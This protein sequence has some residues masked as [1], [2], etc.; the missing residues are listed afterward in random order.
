M[1]VE[2]PRLY[3]R[4]RLDSIF[5]K[6]NHIEQ[7]WSGTAPKIS[8]FTLI[9][10]VLIAIGALI[11]GIF[12]SPRLGFAV[13]N[14]NDTIRDLNL[15]LYA[16]KLLCNKYLESARRKA[17]SDGLLP[18]RCV[19]DSV[20]NDTP[21]KAMENIAIA[22]QVAPK[23]KITKSNFTDSTPPK[24]MK[25]LPSSD[26]SC[27]GTHRHN[28][29]CRFRNLCYSSKREEWIFLKTSQSTIFGFPPKGQKKISLLELSSI[30]N[31]S[32]FYWLSK[33]NSGITWKHLHLYPNSK[34]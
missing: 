8:R 16:S 14:E 18:V 19:E 31:H 25:M 26:V 17:Q 4:K 15:K 30:E 28:R 3:A 22:P 27:T 9:H 1:G 7:T 6:E 32:Y 5:N 13:I 23:P 11:L 20:P 29:I 21:T 10:A 34:I 24:L 2:S 12:A 33:F